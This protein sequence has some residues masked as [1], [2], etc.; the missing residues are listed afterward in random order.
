MKI[1]T[2]RFYNGSL[3]KVT[4][5]GVSGILFELLCVLTETQIMLKEEKDANS[6]KAVRVA[7]DDALEDRG[8][9]RRPLRVIWI[10]RRRGNPTTPRRCGSVWKYRCR[11]GAIWSYGTSCT[12]GRT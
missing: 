12:C 1:T 3:E 6:G 10:G 7:V 2:V 8:D 4:R 5:L 11:P 9:G